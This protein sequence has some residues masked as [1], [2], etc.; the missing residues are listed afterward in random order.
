MRRPSFEDFAA[1]KTREAVAARI[2]SLSTLLDQDDGAERRGI[3]NAWTR[4]HYG[5]DFELVMPSDG[6][7]AVSLVFVQSSD[8]DTGAA[9]PATLGGGDTDKHLIYEGLSRVA[10]DAVLA[11]ARTVRRRTFFSVWHPEL[12]ALRL[13]LG[14]ARHPAQIVISGS[15]SVDFDALLFNVPSVPVFLVADGGAISRQSAWLEA[16]PWIRHIPLT[17]G[18]LRWVLDDLRRT[19][20]VRRI[21]AVGGAFTA[22][23]LVDAGL[24][25]D[26]YLT[27]TA[28]QADGSVMPWY[29]GPAPPLLRVITRKQ[30]LDAGS[31]ITF[32]HLLI[33]SR[34]S[35][36]SPSRR[37]DR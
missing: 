21:S 17:D 22:S 2:E 13:A 28:H 29:S 19:Y 1:E 23:R 4:T 12:V 6:Q 11:G 16:R 26:L 7:T 30:W 14:L 5:G 18:H 34:R 27:T 15:G 31:P 33:T 9:N 20:G 32:A 35:T 8:G 3:G 25:Q 24:A 37:L 10:A 36:S